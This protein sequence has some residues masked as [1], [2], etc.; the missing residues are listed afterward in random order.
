MSSELHKN[1]SPL[2]NPGTP[3]ATKTTAQERL[4]KRL[5]Y[6]DRELEGRS[7]LLG[8][9]EDLKRG[10][11]AYLAVGVR[12]LVIGCAPGA[13]RQLDG[14]VAPFAEVLDDVRRSASVV[15]GGSMNG[16]RA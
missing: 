6:V 10:I 4:L 13:P 5:A 12:H 8:D 3:E 2:F 9:V 16:E 11:E 7:Y 1:F 15:D 14:F